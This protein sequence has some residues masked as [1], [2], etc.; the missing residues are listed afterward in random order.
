M[1]YNFNLEFFII[2]FKLYGIFMNQVL[3]SYKIIVLIVILTRF[4]FVY[5]SIGL[6]CNM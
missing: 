2:N 6:K 1:T 3:K 5:W 4:R